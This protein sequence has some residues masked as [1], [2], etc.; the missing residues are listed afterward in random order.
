M[1]DE[2]WAGL[3]DRLVTSLGLDPDTSAVT[4]DS[5]I[6]EDLG[7][8]SLKTVDLVISLEDEYDIDIADEELAAVATLRDVV[9]LVVRKT[10]PDRA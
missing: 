9:E 4:L 2:V 5:R 10:S 8:S 7:L 6:R 1:F 3:R